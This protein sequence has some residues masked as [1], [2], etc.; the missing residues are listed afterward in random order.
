MNLVHA[1]LLHYDASVQIERENVVRT[2]VD[3]VSFPKFFSLDA[4]E[5]DS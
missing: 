1:S 3:L 2:D 5:V 4:Q